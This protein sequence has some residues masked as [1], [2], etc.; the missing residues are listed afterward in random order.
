MSSEYTL[1]DTQKAEY[2]DKQ[3]EVFQNQVDTLTAR[4]DEL[5]L[6]Q[7]QCNFYAEV[8]GNKQTSCERSIK[9]IKSQIEAA[10]KDLNLWKEYKEK[11]SELW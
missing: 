6:L 10:Y 4:L 2:I 3:I 7:A 5:V 1:T 9:H 8:T 11:H